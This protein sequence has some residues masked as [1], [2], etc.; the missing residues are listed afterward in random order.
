MGWVGTPDPLVAETVARSRFGAVTLDMQH[1]WHGPQ[2]IADGVRAVIL[3]GKAILVRVPVGDFAFA[4]RALD[5]GVEAVIAP[6]VN[7]VDDARA[8]VDAVKYPPLGKR[9]WG[10]GRATNLT[11]L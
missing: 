10:P 2:S 7:T 3:A 1:G 11:G 4:S 9:S 6:M 5:M 8:F